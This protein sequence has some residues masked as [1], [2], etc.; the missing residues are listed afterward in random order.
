MSSW[1]TA[2][3]C[4]FN[5]QNRITPTGLGQIKIDA[6]FRERGISGCERREV[7]LPCSKMQHAI[8]REGEFLQR[9][10]FRDESIC[11]NRPGGGRY[12]VAAKEYD[13]GRRRD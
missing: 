8:D 6:N 12:L 10:G 11:A 1:F 13:S 9:T 3:L 4:G 7:F 2:S 5:W